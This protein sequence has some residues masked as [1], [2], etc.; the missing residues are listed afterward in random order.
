CPNRFNRGRCGVPLQPL[1]HR[2]CTS[3][4]INK[5]LLSLTQLLSCSLSQQEKHYSIKF[6]H[7]KLEYQ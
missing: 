5:T 1:T 3:S 2:Q 7:Y 6:T 4:H